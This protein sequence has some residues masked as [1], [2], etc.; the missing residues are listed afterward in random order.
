M[1][2]LDEYILQVELFSPYLLP[3]TTLLE[4]KGIARLM[5]F[6]STEDLLLMDPY[7][8]QFDIILAGLTEA[9]IEFLAIKAPQPIKTFLL[10]GFTDSETLQSA[11]NLAVSLDEEHSSIKNKERILSVIQYVRDNN[12]V[13]R[14]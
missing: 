10:Q 5:L 13:F 4:Q 1:T 11:Y 12:L 7:S 9:H 2:P 3:A 8:F 6:K 14:F